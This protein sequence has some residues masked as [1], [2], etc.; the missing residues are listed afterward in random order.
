MAEATAQE[1]VSRREL[2]LPIVCVVWAVLAASHAAMLP[3][4]LFPLDDAYIAAHNATALLAGQDASFPGVSALRG[5][6]SLVHLLLVAAMQGLV[7][8][9]WALWCSVWIGTLLLMTGVAR[10]AQLAELPWYVSALLV[11]LSLTAADSAYQLLNGIETGLMM[12]VMVWAFAL[13]LDLARRHSWIQPV[14]VG[15]LPLVRPELALLSALLWLERALAEAPGRRVQR[16]VRDAGI[17]VAVLGPGLFAY[18]FA[19]GSV[20]PQTLNVKRDFFAAPCTSEAAKLAW[21]ANGVGLFIE[22]LNLTALGLL[23]LCLPRVHWVGLTTAFGFLLASALVFPMGVGHNAFRYLYPLVPLCLVGFA[24]AWPRASGRARYVVLA[25]ALAATAGAVAGF[26]RSAVL[27]LGDLR[28]TEDEIA[29]AAAFVHEHLAASDR[30]LLHD[31]GYVSTAVPNE[32]IDVVGLKDPRA[33]ALQHVLTSARC[34]PETR[35][36]V[37]ARLALE[38]NARHLIVF[39]E[40]DRQFQLTAGLQHLGWSLT[41]LRAPNVVYQVYRLVPPRLRP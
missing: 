7:S 20:T 17:I 10:L 34:E 27:Y 11:A 40:W 14:V 15:M 32:L 23:L 19:T 12:A 30:V 5:A 29:P 22:R 37:I 21:F 38:R 18:W 9:P 16:G 33:A 36:A 24:H 31:I 8:P 26:P 35:A 25:L 2:M 1:D 28:L 13:R 3:V 41:A 4:P 6:T 39:A